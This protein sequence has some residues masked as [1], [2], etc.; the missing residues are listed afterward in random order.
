MIMP[1]QLE[2]QTNIYPYMN[3]AYW[4]GNRIGI[5]GLPCGEFLPFDHGDF[6]RNALAG[7]MERLALGPLHPEKKIHNGQ[8][9]NADDYPQGTIIRYKREVIA[10]SWKGRYMPGVEGQE[11]PERPI[12]T[13]HFNESGHIKHKDVGRYG[14]ATHYAVVTPPVKG[15]QTIISGQPT[16]FGLDVQNET[17]NTTTHHRSDRKIILW[18]ALPQNFE[19]GEVLG[20]RYMLFRNSPYERRYARVL[21]AEVLGTYGKKQ[22]KR[23]FDLFRVL[24]PLEDG[25]VA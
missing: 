11:L 10:L 7:Y 24:K 17:T 12:G 14:Y 6:A 3:P 23:V 21:G 2:G 22:S 8:R 13:P 16:V 4:D 20:R 19:V 5:D 25:G 18:R 9:F 1:N 15:K